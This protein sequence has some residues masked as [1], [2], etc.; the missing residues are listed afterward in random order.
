M[1][2]LMEQFY[3]WFYSQ[4]AMKQGETK[5]LKQNQNWIN[6][7]WIM[8]LKGN[9]SNEAPTQLIASVSIFR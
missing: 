4:I 8:F 5:M 7:E 2:L 1:D 6:N 9:N 3:E